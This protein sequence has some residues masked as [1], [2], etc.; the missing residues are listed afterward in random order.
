MTDNTSPAAAAVHSFAATTAA[1][2]GPLRAFLAVVRAARGSVSGPEDVAAVLA[3]REALGELQ[4]VC[5][6]LC[7]SF[8]ALLGEP[9]DKEN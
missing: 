3:A 7:A 8:D 6:E 9:C 5:S 1:A 4:G 2:V